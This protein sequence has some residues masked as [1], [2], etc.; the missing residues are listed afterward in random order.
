MTEWNEGRQKPAAIHR[1][2]TDKTGRKLKVTL[3]ASNPTRPTGLQA[4]GY[5]QTRWEVRAKVVDVATKEV[6]HNEQ[7]VGSL[8]WVRDTS[9]AWSLGAVT[10]LWAHGNTLGVY[11]AAGKK[12]GWSYKTGTFA[13]NKM[14]DFIE[15]NL[16]KEVSP[17][18][19][20]EA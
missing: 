12:S 2:I 18:K 14:M 6:V 20:T 10:G 1:T 4:V 17:L 8:M 11:D 9:V 16:T 3:S 19:T 7:N 13:I 5:N 15:R